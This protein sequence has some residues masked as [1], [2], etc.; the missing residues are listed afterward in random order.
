MVESELVQTKGLLD[1]VNDIDK[2]I[3]KEFSDKY[4]RENIYINS[5]K[6]ASS[7]MFD[8][9]NLAKN[10]IDYRVIHKKLKYRFCRFITSYHKLGLIEKYNGKIYKKVDIPQISRDLS[11]KAKLIYIGDGHFR[12]KSL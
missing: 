10:T 12:N 11:K 9:Y 5:R 2:T 3:L 6:L 1:F 8:T 4:L 7:Y